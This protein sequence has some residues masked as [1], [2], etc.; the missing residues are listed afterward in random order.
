MKKIAIFC[1]ALFLGASFVLAYAEEA[2]VY[3]EPPVVINAKVGEKVVITLDSNKTTGYSWEL[4][5]PIDKDII[6]LL[7]NKYVAPTANRSGA[8][9]KEVWTFRATGRGKV[10]LTFRYLRSWEKNV[11][12][13]KKQAYIIIIK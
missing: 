7:D 5:K 11:P 10:T 6:G 13:A 3:T 12:S 8:P 2:E 9:G 4:V 1:A